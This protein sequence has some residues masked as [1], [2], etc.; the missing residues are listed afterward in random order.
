MVQGKDGFLW[1]GTGT[2]LYRFD[3]MHFQ[4]IVPTGDT[5]F[6]SSDISALKLLPDGN[7]WIGFYHGGVSVVRHGV[8]H[9]YGTVSGFPEGPV[10][11]FA[12]DGEGVLWVATQGG[13]AR[14]V[15]HHWQVVGKGW[16]Y[17]TTR[18]DWVLAGHSGAL[19][20]STGQRLLFLRKGSHHFL[21]TGIAVSLFAVIAQSPDGTLWLSDGLHG[22]R[23]LPGLNASHPV[24]RQSTSLPI[25]RFAW[26]ERL[27]FDHEG[28][29]WATDAVDGGAFLVNHPNRLE[30]GHSLVSADV[31]CRFRQTNGLTSDRAVP[32]LQDHEGD[33]WVGTNLGLNSFRRDD[34]LPLPD[35]N[36]LSTV[37]FTM[38]MS[39]SGQLWVSNGGSLYRIEHGQPSRVLTGLGEIF[40][41]YATDDGTV[42][43]VGDHTFMRMTHGQ[44][45][46]VALPAH[47]DPDDVSTLAVDRSGTLWL[48]VQ[49]HGVYHYRNGSWSAWK[50][51]RKGFDDTPVIMA[52]GRDGGVWL[53][54]TS[55]RLL[56]VM[57]DGSRVFAASD[58][59]DIGDITAITPIRGGALVGGDTGM[60]DIQ[61]GRVTTLTT[62]RVPALRGISGIVTTPEGTVWLNTS[63]GIVRFAGSNLRHALNHADATAKYRLFD[64]QEGLKGVAMQSPDTTTAFRAADGRLWFETSTNIESIDPGHLTHNSVPPRCGCLDWMPTGM[65]IPQQTVCACPSGPATSTSGTPQ[66]ALRYQAMFISGIASTGWTPD[67]RMPAIGARRSIPILDRVATSSRSSQPTTMVSGTG[68]AQASLS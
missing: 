51:D 39:P 54:Y 38:S 31:N 3:G 1:L 66:Q 60:A 6:A 8:A 14:F 5:A 30:D 62:R 43:M 64:Y 42:W 27:L 53:G 61:A 33:V 9:Y 19:W 26:S 18:A 28:R 56:H 29:L 57:D 40:T 7:L 23:A 45:A 17:P 10:E 48:A 44:A 35:L 50:S 34:V 47:V 24:A 52:A 55:N 20:V 11:T 2:G 36:T 12:V 63:A 4:H 37:N 16:N 25:T 41:T 32:L 13:L 65:R 46:P 21:D 58:G 59:L 68:R 67:G 15:D 49:K 22:T